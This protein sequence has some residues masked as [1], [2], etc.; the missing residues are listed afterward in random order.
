MLYPFKHH[1]LFSAILTQKLTWNY[2]ITASFRYKT[3]ALTHLRQ[4]IIKI[5]RTPCLLVGFM[6]LLWYNRH[7]LG[8]ILVHWDFCK[9]DHAHCIDFPS[10]HF[11]NN[12]ISDSFIH[13]TLI[14]AD[15]HWSIRILCLLHLAIKEMEPIKILVATV[16]SSMQDSFIEDMD[17]KSSSS[18]KQYTAYPSNI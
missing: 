13:C 3:L 5:I 1:N 16:D 14:K 10:V 7:L 17:W 6:A 15:N 12:V 4:Y 11:L 9:T 18:I 8:N 2:N